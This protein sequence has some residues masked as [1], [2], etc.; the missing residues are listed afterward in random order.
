[1][2]RLE[3]ILGVLTL[4]MVLTGGCANNQ[5]TAEVGP[6]PVPV[7]SPTPVSKKP[8]P[9]ATPIVAATPSKASRLPLGWEKGSP[10]RKAWSEFVYRLISEELF[11]LLD[12]AGDAQRLCP[13]YLRLERDERIA[14]WSELISAVA[15][16]ESG[17]KPSEQYRETDMGMDRVTGKQ[18]VSEGLLQLS[19]QDIPNYGS[20]LKYPLCKIDFAA[21]SRLDT[22]D[23]K[24][25]I[26]DPLIN[27]ECGLRIL[28]R[29][30]QR[31]GN[32]IL[33]SGVYWSVLRESSKRVPQIIAHVRALS[34]CQ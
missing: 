19:Y 6:S 11:P 16:Y 13:N 9:S 23:P 8:L 18:V 14:V 4:A 12:T 7:L 17:W 34:F 24:R 31:K 2:V 26:L 32:V 25:T 20:V 1:M 30:V 27:L 28:A 29:Q 3:L 15:Y 5:P 21:D 22:S 33:A 10:H